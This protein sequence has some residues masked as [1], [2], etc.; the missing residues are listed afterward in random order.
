MKKETDGILNWMIDGLYLYRQEGLIPP[1][2]IQQ[3]TEEY[4]ID[5]DK[6][7]RFLSECLMKSDKNVSAKAVYETYSKWCT[8]SGLG[9]DGRNNFYTELKIKGIFAASGTVNGK[10]V[11]N[12]V[13][14]YVLAEEEFMPAED[15][16]QIPFD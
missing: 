14:G 13:R 12:V 8:D 5:S 2:A 1:A 15:N 11:R 6:I 9:V 16:L 4:E 3:S 7:G 10:T